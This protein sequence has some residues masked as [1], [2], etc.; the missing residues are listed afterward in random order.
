MTRVKVFL[1][2]TTGI[3]C[4]TPYICNG[5]A[6]DPGPYIYPA[7]VHVTCMTGFFLQDG[8]S[9]YTIDCQDDG[10]WNRNDSC[11]GRSFVLYFGP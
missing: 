3:P 8:S 7:S 10:T 1:C 11:I 9:D 5:A 2:Y 6:D 4:E